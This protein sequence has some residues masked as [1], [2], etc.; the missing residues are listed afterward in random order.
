MS[1][2]RNLTQRVYEHLY[3]ILHGAG[4]D[5][6]FLTSGFDEDSEHQNDELVS[7]STLRRLEAVTP[8]NPIEDKSFKFLELNPQILDTFFNLSDKVRVNGYEKYSATTIMEK[9]RWDSDIT[10]TLQFNDDDDSGFALNDHMKC[11]LSRLYNE[12]TI[13][14]SPL[15]HIRPRQNEDYK[16]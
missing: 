13:E 15:F 2:V 1:R 3:E 16:I 4:E 8:L 14:R 12:A 9:M 10:Q 5:Y 6:G 11:I 7:V